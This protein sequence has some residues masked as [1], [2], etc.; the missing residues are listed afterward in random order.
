MPY[1][2]FITDEDLLQH[3]QTLVDA[4]L[5]AARGVE[6]NPHKNVVDPFSAL[7]DSARQGISLHDWMK[8]EESRQIQKSFQNAVGDFHQRILGSISGW[9]NAGSGGSFDI[10]NEERKIIAEIKN[11][12]NTMNAGAER[13]VYDTMANWLDY[14]KDG[15]T[16]YVVS[17]VPKSPKPYVLPFVASERGVK[18]PTRNNL[19]KIDGRSFYELASGYEDAIDQLYAVLPSVLARALDIDEKVLRGTDDFKEVF[20]RAYIR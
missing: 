8:Q 19:L 15:Y 5:G 3:T 20:E 17:I 13:A 7:V 6:K 9:K 2:A 11:K 16:A 10:I 14:G 4:A 1:L 18:R 12:H